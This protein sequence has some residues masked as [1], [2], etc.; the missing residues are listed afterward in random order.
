MLRKV[1]DVDLQ[2]TAGSVRDWQYFLLAE[3]DR[4]V[5]AAQVI[6]ASERATAPSESEDSSPHPRASPSPQPHH[7]PHQ[8][9]ARGRSRD[10]PS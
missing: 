3:L 4:G 5:E 8:P 1:G 9:L 2:T 6:E 10:P 7:P